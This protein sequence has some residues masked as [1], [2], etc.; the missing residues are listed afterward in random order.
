MRIWSPLGPITVLL[1]AFLPLFGALPSTA[2]NG[3]CQKRLIETASTLWSVLEEE[4]LLKRVTASSTNADFQKGGTLFFWFV[5]QG[6]VYIEPDGFEALK[7]RNEV[8]HYA[9]TTA[10]MVNCVEHDWYGEKP[11]NIWL[12]EWFSVEDIRVGKRPRKLMKLDRSGNFWEEPSE[13]IEFLR[14]EHNRPWLRPLIW[15]DN[16][17]QIRS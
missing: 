16:S 2:Q 1:V 12:T 10:I 15:I 7:I 9:R 14:H 4:R 6:L 17:F 13:T 5:S 11:A 3:P 8:L